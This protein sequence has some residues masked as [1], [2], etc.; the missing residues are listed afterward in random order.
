[1]TTPRSRGALAPLLACALL[2]V[3]VGCAG[4]APGAD[5]RATDVPEIAVESESPTASPTPP[6]PPTRAF[7][8]PILD[9]E[10]LGLLPDYPGQGERTF[11][12]RTW[13]NV[14]IDGR[15]ACHGDVAL[16]G[17]AGVDGVGFSIVVADFGDSAEG[18]VLADECCYRGE[19]IADAAS[20]TR[21]ECGRAECFSIVAVNGFVAWTRVRAT[22]EVAG[23]PDVVAGYHSSL[24]SHVRDV[25]TAAARP[26]PLPSTLADPMLPVDCASQPD[27]LAV[28]IG[29][30]FGLAGP[31]ESGIAYTHDQV[32]IDLAANEYSGI[33]L[34]D[35]RIDDEPLAPVT[36]ISGVDSAELTRPGGPFNSEGDYPQGLWHRYAVGGGIL[37]V[38]DVDR[39]TADA[40]ADA[41]R[42]V[43][44]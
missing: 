23:A 15:Y 25:L 22:A 41:Y 26:F 33:H 16:D 9:T 24:A 8:A 6:T 31:A 5:R 21:L 38:A 34:C 30:V 4:A 13:G 12:E 37:V 7:G 19:V 3:A 10:C 43:L 20:P 14:E 32:W 40:V 27:E 2:L 18:A 17:A 1:M 29:E 28:A 11:S 36:L 42:A 39:A 35:W 44:D